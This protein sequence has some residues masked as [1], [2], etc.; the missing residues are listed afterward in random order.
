M[1]FPLLVAATALG[2][3]SGANAF[4]QTSQDG[5]TRAQVHEQLIEAQ[6][7]GLLPVPKNHYPP[8][9][10]TIAR[11]KELYA[12]QHQGGARMAHS[13]DAQKAPAGS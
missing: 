6:A 2:L 13:T 4:A 1:K 11:N 9:A 10:E 12:F 7:D 3:I 5:L 8:S